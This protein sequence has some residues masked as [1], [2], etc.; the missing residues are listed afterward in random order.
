MADYYSTLTSVQARATTLKIQTGV[1]DW[2]G[3]TDALADSK[4]EILAYVQPRYGSTVTDLWTDTTR[5]DFIGLLSDWM[6]L[7]RMLTGNNAEHP[8]AI[9]MY[10]ECQEK[11]QK[12][13][14]YEL[15]IPGVEYVSG[16]TNETT[17]MRYLDYTQSEIDSGDADPTSYEYV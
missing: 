6:T 4:S 10:A 13:A 16:Q 8:V 11:L 17:R 9:R 7:Y 2:T 14:N 1:I 15:M 5:P 3:I 12:V